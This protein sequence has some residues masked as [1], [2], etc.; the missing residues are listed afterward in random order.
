MQHPDDI[1]E[2]RALYAIERV[3]VL[4]DAVDA[5]KDL[6]EC[7][8]AG[9]DYRLSLD[10]AKREAKTALNRAMTSANQQDRA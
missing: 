4:E 1:F 7:L 9:G 2:R 8:D 6:L 5:L 10:E 3:P